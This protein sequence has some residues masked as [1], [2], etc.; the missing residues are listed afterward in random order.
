MK[1]DLDSI[2]SALRNGSP[3][4]DD[5]LYLRVGQCTLRVLS[6][7]A[8]LLA[9]LRD[10]FAHVVS[11]AVT[12]DIEVI[13]I[14]RAGP[15]LGVAF[16]DWK[17]EPGKSGR[18]D[19]YLD[20]PA[21][22]LLLKVRT[23]ML[24]L[25]SEQ[26]RIAAGPCLRY[27]S[28]LINFINAQYMNWLQQRSWLICHASALVRHGRG[29]A[30][31]GLSGGG[32]S[33]L[34]LKLLDE[35]SVSYMTNDRLFIKRESATTQAIGI[36]KLPRINPGTI[37]HNAKLQHLIDP[38]QR[39]E[40]LK[41]PPQALWELEDKYDVHVENI[42][43]S[44][45]IV[46][47]AP[48]SAFLILN[49]QRDSTRALQLA[50]VDLASRRDLLAAIM[51]SPGPFYQ[52]ADGSFYRDDTPFDEQAYVDALEG[53]RIFEASGRVDFAALTERCLGEVMV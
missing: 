16:T 36:P 50:P 25:Q 20:I 32:K 4:C 33:T 11:T 37:I 40:L 2:A 45:R 3:L 41:L 14:E 18:K 5:A 39:E 8:Q 28:Q 34:M 1:T 17:R 6:N 9:L 27:D 44:G 19:A 7:S 24:F 22:R 49:W 23:G 46:Q 43:G 15:D 47:Q 42:Y 51:K 31:A 38:Q 30:I 53:V 52:Y 10:Y 35:D 29:F 26:Y 48:L 21:G 12:P 13:A